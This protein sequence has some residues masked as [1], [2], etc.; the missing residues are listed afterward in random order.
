GLANACNGII[1]VFSEKRRRRQRR[2]P[3]PET[4]DAFWGLAILLFLSTLALRMMVSAWEDRHLVALLPFFTLFTGAGLFWI[5]EV[6]FRRHPAALIAAVVTVTGIF[7]MNCALTPPKQ[8]LGLDT[9]AAD[10]ATDS[11]FR[12]SRLLIL[13]DSIGEGAFVA[14]VAMHESR[15]GHVVERGSKV[16][17]SDGFMGD[18]YQLKY[19]NGSDVMRFQRQDPSRLVIID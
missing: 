6:A 3:L 2:G 11:R 17:A 10:L 14:E 19:Q 4:P 18:N 5:V 13:S 15:P 1:I 12:S 16:L 9:V 8:H 7:A